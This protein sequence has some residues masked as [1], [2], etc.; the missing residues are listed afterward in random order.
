MWFKQFQKNTAV[1][2]QVVADLTRPQ[3]LHQK[4]PMPAVIVLAR[5]KHADLLPLQIS[6]S[7]QP[8]AGRRNVATQE[9]HLSMIGRDDLGGLDERDAAMLPAFHF[10]GLHPVFVHDLP[11]RLLEVALLDLIAAWPDVGDGD[12][13]ISTMPVVKERLRQG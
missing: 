5:N 7:N 1:L 6:R 4:A 12:V 8:D 11:D 2:D 13:I 10:S 9:L 3:D